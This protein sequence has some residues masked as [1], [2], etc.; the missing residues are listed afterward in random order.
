M[1]ARSITIRGRPEAIDEGIAFVRDEVQ[2]AITASDGCLGLSLVV[3]RASGRCIATSSWET[4]EAMAVAEDDLA[5]L[6][7]RAGEILGGEPVI[8]RWEIAL[9]HRVQPAGE[10]AWC[11]KD[12]SDKALA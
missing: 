5:P 9:M 8:D 6:R 7:L 2:P 4:P 10:G 3:D 1:Y 11:R 12:I